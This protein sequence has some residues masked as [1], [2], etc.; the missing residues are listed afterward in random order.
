[1]AMPPARVFGDPVARRVGDQLTLSDLRP[2]GPVRKYP[3]LCA[4]I[5][6]LDILLLGHAECYER[7]CRD[8]PVPHVR[9]TSSDSAASPWRTLGILRL[10]SSSL[11]GCRASSGRF[12][13]VRCHRRIGGCFLPG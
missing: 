8:G 4:G 12:P 1:M 11:P 7:V 2:S 13:P 5:G 9:L 6:S 3:P 10:P